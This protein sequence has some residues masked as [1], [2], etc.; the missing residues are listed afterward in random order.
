M[1]RGLPKSLGGVKRCGQDRYVTGTAAKM[2]A[3]K[4]AQLRLRGL[5]MR[6]QI[7][8]ERHQDAGGAEAA[9]QRVMSAECLLQHGEMARFGRERLDPPPI[10]RGRP[11]HTPCPQPTGVP[12]MPRSWRRKSVNNMRGS[13]SASTG[14]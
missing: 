11:P 4:F 9:L 2:T 3:K 6:A 8:I 5:R 12:V 1:G 10:A 13:A 14:R 7:G